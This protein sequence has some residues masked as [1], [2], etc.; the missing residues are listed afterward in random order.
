MFS[1]LSFSEIKIK[2]AG[3]FNIFSSDDTDKGTIILSEYSKDFV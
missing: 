2:K 1:C 3:I